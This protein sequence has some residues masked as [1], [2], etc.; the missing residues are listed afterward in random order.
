MRGHH[1]GLRGGGKVTSE[2]LCLL[3]IGANWKARFKQVKIM[4]GT[5]LR[6]SK[7]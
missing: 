7:G 2:F 1:D 6:C 5:K 3:L 4:A